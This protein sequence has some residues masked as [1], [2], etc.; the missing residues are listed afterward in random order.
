[1]SETTNTETELFSQRDDMYMYRQCQEGHQNQEQDTA[2]QSRTTVHKM[3][4][5][6]SRGSS[7]PKQFSTK[8]F[9]FSWIKKKLFVKD[10]VTVHTYT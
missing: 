3:K 6:I 7:G 2:T 5:S 1:M 8:C 10:N 9:S 4:A